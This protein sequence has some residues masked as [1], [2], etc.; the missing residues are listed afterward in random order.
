MFLILALR[1]KRT[2]KKR[3]FYNKMGLWVSSSY[4]ALTFL[5]KWIA[6][7]QIESAL[8]TQ[9][10]DYT[11]IDTRPSPLNTILWS[12]NVETKNAYLLGNYSFFDTKVITF[13]SYPKNH[14]LLGDL[15]KNESIQRM[16]SI[17]E[18]WYII[19]KKNEFLYFND[20]RFGLLSLA[21]KSQDF[22]FKYRIDID[23]LGNVDFVE[24]PKDKR[25][26]KKLL[27][28][29]WIRLKGN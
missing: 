21:P 9:K 15:T 3:E 4:L 1:Q 11:Q 8:K 24:E 27:S 7:S 16:I 14:D 25:D 28:D 2:A 13:E 29:L 6:F 19:N 17:S 26:G 22:V 20:L 12:A 10:I 18:G 5:L 23:S